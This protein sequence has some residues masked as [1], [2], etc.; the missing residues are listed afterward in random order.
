M[1]QTL[2]TT[3]LIIGGGPGGY[4]AAIRA[5][6][7]GIPTILVEGQALGGTCLN[8]G[9]IPSK[10]LIHV[11]EQFH[12][13]RLFTTPSALGISVPSATLDISQS[14]NWKNGIVDRLTTGVAALLKKNKVQV[15]HGWARVIDGK[16]VEVAGEKGSQ[17]I[18][19]EHLLLATGSTSVNLPMLP[20]GGPII[21]STEALT[22]EAI[23]KHLV[24]VGAGYIGLELG[25]AY[26]KLGAE[27]SVVEARDRILPAYDQELTQPIAETL[28]HLGVKL[29]LQHS[30]QGFDPETRILQVRDPEGQALTLTAD[31]V[32]VAVGRKP[33]SQGW[34]LEALGL[35]MNGAAVKID[36]RC[37]TSMRNVWAIG[38]LAGEPMLAHRAMAQG[39]MVAELIAGNAREFNPV[40]IA[41]VCFTDPELVV[42]G[43]TPEEAN[44]LGLDCLV[45]SFPFA[46]NG[47]AMTL[48]SKSGFV[49]VVARRDNHLIVGWQA[50]GVGVSELST[51][52]AQSLEMGARLEDIA[53]TI[54]AHPTLGEAVH[55]AALRALGHA[56]HL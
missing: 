24:V 14:V 52:F 32:L 37:Q 43:K 50:V 35:D 55:E 5:G 46:A 1:P 54:H 10:A 12:Q 16:T 41:A 38:D 53:G 48:E 31:Q 18:Q 8:V 23:P 6:Q 4:V 17:R 7:L 45:A 11:A 30:V 51:A 36:D 9:C 39:E 3:L 26:R 44:A 2:S 22:P 20:L 42:V 33:N 40:A 27:V 15:I 34:N 49:R 25:I 28:K 56:L 47:R 19:C 29:Y 21:S 13:T